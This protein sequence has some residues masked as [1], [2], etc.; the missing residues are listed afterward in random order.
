MATTASLP[1]EDEETSTAPVELQGAPDG[2]TADVAVQSD[3]DRAVPPDAAAR[4]FVVLLLHDLPPDVAARLLDE[5]GGGQ[6]EVHVIAPAADR[7]WDLPGRG[8]EFHPAVS[9]VQINWVL[10]MIGN[11]D[12]VVDAWSGDA[13]A[14]V[15]TWDRAFLHLRAGGTY[16]ILRSAVTSASEYDKLTDG[17]YRRSRL[18][19]G[20]DGATTRLVGFAEACGDLALRADAIDVGKL[21]TDFFKVRDAEA[22]RAMPRRSR[23]G[24]T[25][26]L[27]RLPA[28]TFT[29]RGRTYFHPE[30]VDV[31]PFDST[32][33]V[34]ERR[35][36]LYEGGVSVIGNCLAVKDTTVIPESYRHHMEKSL[37]NPRLRDVDAEFAR[38]DD[39]D[40]A[41]DSLPGVYYHLDASNSGHFGHLT[42]EVLSKLWG[43]DAAVERCPDIKAIFRIRYPNERDPALER[44]LFT[45]F[46]I[47]ED[48]IQVI[49]RPMKVDA[50][51][52]A[53]PLWHNQF[54]HYVDPAI[55]QTWDR[56]SHA[57]VDPGVPGHE[58]LFVSR[59]PSLSNRRC[60]NTAEVERHFADRGFAVIYPEDLDLGVQASLFAKARVVA[61]FGG[62]ALFNSM[63]SKR[64]ET[65]IVLT[66]TA[67]TARNEHM[68]GAVL[69]CDVHY[70]WNTPNVPHPPGGWSEEAYFSD[71]TFDFRTLGRELD[72]VLRRV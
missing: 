32:Y 38:I 10:K 59:R 23:S 57:L 18:R 66:H 41:T 19:T 6:D 24:P 61:G 11:P 25:T 33:A 50:L 31:A 46:G 21:G 36:R 52:A 44:R 9:V 53:T 42:T 8:I 7:A 67:Y 70:F 62:S 63:F 54:P 40:V 39:R 1:G 47:R 16:T 43:W 55:E 49:D 35:V 13:D 14:H 58:K 51:V 26:E 20:D 69:G 29:P 27:V 37:R 28:S 30:T 60:L 45:A 4:R 12:A 68:Y 3:S 71:W 2:S 22:S 34:P 56:M 65:M 64:L 48:Q 5:H 15:A 17:V 72:K